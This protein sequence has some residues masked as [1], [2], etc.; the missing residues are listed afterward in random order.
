MPSVPL[1]ENPSLEHLKGQAKL[2]RDLIRAD[3]PGGLSML[4]EFHPRLASDAMTADQ[5]R[6]FKTTD[7]QL[8]VA[9]LYGFESWARLRNHLTAVEDLSFTPVA[10]EPDGSPQSETDKRVASFVINACLDYAESGP[11]PADRIAD[12]R[13]MLE[14]D[15][16]LATAS[17]AALATVGDHQ[18]LADHLDQHPDALDEPTGPNRWPPLLY[19]TYSRISPAE[20]GGSAVE[21][22]RS[23]V[24]TVRLLLDRGADPDCGFLW[25]GLVPPFTALTGALG[26]GESHQPLHPDRLEM[27]RLLL[28]AGADPNDG[29]ALYNNGI[30][31]QDHDDPSH[32]ELLVA[33]GLGTARSGPWHERLGAQLRDPA[34]LLYDELEAAVLR[35]RPAVLRFL[36][37]LDLDLDRPIGRSGQTP[38]R[39]ASGE[40]HGEILAILTEAGLDTDPTPTEQALQYVR[41]GGVADLRRVLDN[42]LELADQLRAGHPG[43]CRMVGAQHQPMLEFLIEQGF[44]INDRSDTKTALHRATEADDPDR[45]RLL[46]DHGADPNLVDTHIGATPLG[47]ANHFH[48]DNAAAALE[49]V[50]HDGEPLPEVTIGCLDHT[51]TLATQVLVERHLDLL[52]R[53][54]EEPVLA[55]I[56]VG[57]AA[58]TI[59]LGHQTLSVALL[60]D[61]D[62]TPWGAKGSAPAGGEDPAFRDHQTARRFNHHLPTAAVRAAVRSFLQHPDKKPAGLEWAKEGSA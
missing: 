20:T 46:L 55:T 12:A 50:T 32:L 44:D 13:R 37:S 57:R 23:A 34:E 35:N 33:H 16:S 62:G 45:I 59:G 17:V 51:R 15:P 40:G 10:E 43:L 38:V 52:D 27:A 21:T 1:P 2:V 18:A 24:E 53:T 22:D 14:A 30:G 4:D 61:P 5:R 6:R 56:R 54:A 48:H 19:V 29:Q 47:W 26:R 39:I 49:P 9:R 58:L 31:G 36:V 7:A 25:R 11:S 3:D 60:L 42:H 28:E 8:M 41:N